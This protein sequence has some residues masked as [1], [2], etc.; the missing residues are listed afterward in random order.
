MIRL[1][2]IGRKNDPSFRVVVVDSHQGPKSGKYVDLIGSYNPKMDT[3]SI[4]GERV[5]HWIKNGAQVSDTMHN[6]LIKE[7][8]IEGKK[9][10]VLPK[11][12]PIVKET[13]EAKEDD[14]SAGAEET[15]E[16][17][18]GGSE[19]ASSEIVVEDISKEEEK[20]EEE[21]EAPEV[22]EEVSEEE[23]KKA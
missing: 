11:K 15:E 16:A 2:R 12:S 8:I 9:K 21:V 20:K 4:D 10:N 5:K 6:I 19:P 1:Q 3:V 13:V 17:V 18:S 14:A 22:K 23:D 7:G